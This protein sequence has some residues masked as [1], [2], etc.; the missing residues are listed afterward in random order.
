MTRNRSRRGVSRQLTVL[1]TALLGVAV[2]V[3]LVGGARTEEASAGAGVPAA[4]PVVDCLT[5]DL[6]GAL[7][8]QPRRAG[9]G[10]RDAVLRLTNTSG[11]TCR[12][13]G[14]PDVA[15]VTPPGE[16]VRVPTRAIS[17]PGADAVIVLAPEA[18]AWSRVQWDTC[19]PGRSGCGVGVAVQYIVD[20][21]STGAAADPEAL[22]E[23]D[24]DGI[25]MKA[26]RVGPLQ[27]TR[28]AALL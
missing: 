21:E 20:A 19:K 10:V 11:R 15:L 24:L 6:T 16:V 8:G 2:A 17:Q 26:L 3:A 1:T 27:P 18:G 28:A 23:A 13:Q 7:I 12:V 25:T 14:R 9:S 4:G 22:P 5:E